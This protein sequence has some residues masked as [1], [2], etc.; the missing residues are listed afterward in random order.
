MLEMC[1][2]FDCLVFQV[3]V[4]FAHEL[5]R[6]VLEDDVDRH[7]VDKKLVKFPSNLEQHLRCLLFQDVLCDV[8]DEE[9]PLWNLYLLVLVEGVAIDPARLKHQQSPSYASLRL[10]R[11]PKGQSV[12]KSEMFLLRHLVDESLHFLLPRRLHSHAHAPGLHWVDDLAQV[13]AR[14]HQSALLAVLFHRPP[15]SVLSVSR[16]P[17][18]LVDQKNLVRALLSC[19]RLVLLSSSSP[20]PCCIAPTTLA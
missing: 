9:L 8:L 6:Q 2:S 19:L 14:H 5:P 4:E 17:I 12:R 16:Q 18:H 1:R 15:Q 20:F 7:A 10:F 13:R 11:D 3:V